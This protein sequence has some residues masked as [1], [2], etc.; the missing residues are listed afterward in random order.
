MCIIDRQFVVE[1]DGSIT[2][3][4]ILRG[5]DPDLDKEAIRVISAMPVSYTHLDV[6]KRQ[7]QNIGMRHAGTGSAASLQDA[8]TIEYHRLLTFRQVYCQMCIRDRYHRDH[9]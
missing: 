2:N 1:K 5:I 3:V 9:R 8:G 7:F 4:K 6:Y